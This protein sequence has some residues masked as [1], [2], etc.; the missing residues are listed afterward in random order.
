MADVITKPVQVDQSGKSAGL[1]GT[2]VCKQGTFKT[3]RGEQFCVLVTQNGPPWPLAVSRSTDGG[4]TWAEQDSA[5][6][7]DATIAAAVIWCDFDPVADIIKIAFAVN[8]SNPTTIKLYSFSTL[9]REYAAAAYPDLTDVDAVGGLPGIPFVVR[10]DGSA[11][12]VY[13]TNSGT[14]GF[15]VNVAGV[16]AGFAT[17]LA[18]AAH[19]YLSMG[20]YL[21]AATQTTHVIFTDRTGG[22]TTWMHLT[23]DSTNTP[24][25]PDTIA[26]A[27]SSDVMGLGAISGGVLY[28]PLARGFGDSRATIFSG[29]PLS[30]PI[31][32]VTDLDVQLTNN[33]VSC[34]VA[35]VDGKVTA[36]W[37]FENNAGTI[38]VIRKSLLTAGVW[39]APGV[40]YDVNALPPNTVPLGSQFV[41][42]VNVCVGSLAAL[43]TMLDLTFAFAAFFMAAPSPAP[44]I[45]TLTFKGLKVYP[46]L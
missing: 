36:L 37:D 34:G 21:D 7:P 45:L 3:I 16:W 30:A 23:I 41:S 31:W 9:T 35:E 24:S 1:S 4:A 19:T 28:L 27:T 32:T 40:Y 43:V 46:R 5:N 2:G 17:L 29:A 20:T 44:P 14:L 8:T 6:A 38:N 25:A 11:L 33:I 13:I 26:V 15:N 22:V 18:V 42:Q 12:A 10:A 39:G